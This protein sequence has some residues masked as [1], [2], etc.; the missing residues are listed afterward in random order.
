MVQEEEA[1][2]ETGRAGVKARAGSIHSIEERG[3]RTGD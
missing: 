1:K 3:E 2:A